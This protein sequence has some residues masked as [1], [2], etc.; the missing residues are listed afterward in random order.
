MWKFSDQSILGGADELHRQ[1]AHS[2]Q[3]C[4]VP[5][6]DCLLP[7]P[8]QPCQQFAKMYVCLLFILKKLILKFPVLPT[9]SQNF[10]L[11]FGTPLQITRRRNNRQRV[12]AHV[13]AEFRR[14]SRMMRRYQA[15]PYAALLKNHF[16]LVKVCFFTI[17][18]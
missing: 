17:M 4:S 15:G 8:E 13:E 7:C 5:S 3:K 2:V 16:E 6:F 14:Y 10:W 12:P 1:H 9:L 11:K 18:F